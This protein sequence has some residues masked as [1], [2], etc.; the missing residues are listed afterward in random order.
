M[1]ATSAASL[2]SL[3]L[4][5]SPLVYLAGHLP[6]QTRWLTP[7]L[8]ALAAFGA[9][10]VAYLAVLV[11]LRAQGALQLSVEAV[12]LRIDGI[13]LLVSGLALALGTVVVIYS[14]PYVAGDTGEEK[15]YAMIMAMIGAI[16]GLVCAQDLFNLWIWFETMA[17]SSYLLVAFHREQL[18]SL[19]AGVKYLVQSA[20]GSALVLLGVALVLAQTGTLSLDQIRRLGAQSPSIAAAGALFIIGFGVKIALVPL[21][22]W[23]PDAH[24][25]APSGVS[26]LL[27]GIVIEAG[28]I[29]LLRALSPLTAISWGEWLVA[30]ALL[31]IFFGNLLALRQQE[32]KRLLAFSSV[33]QIGY[34]LLG[35]GIA[36]E[37][38]RPEGAQ[39]GLLHL[40]THG[41]MKGLSFLAVGALFYALHASKGDHRPLVIGDLQ[42]AARRYPLTTAALTIALIGLAG[43]PPT[44]GFVSKF[45]V[46]AAGVAAGDS[47]LLLATA[48]AAVNSLLSIAYYIPLVI[49]LYRHDS[50]AEVEGGSAVPRSMTVPMAAMALS[51]LVIGVVP[52]LLQWLTAL[53]GAD[54]VAWIR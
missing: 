42:G 9:M 50:G 11:D 8:T 51:V 52:N 30:F 14:G 10:W 35:L 16:I 1:F 32:V 20:C 38:G 37:T 28:L 23:L 31:N 47:A 6:R 54:V 45:Q 39:A 43:I 33:S 26:A 24:A 15:Y 22:T 25:Q 36:L 3:P 21:H 53:A 12:F 49:V 18:G 27:S 40:L 7:R 2:I 34:M 41:V 17:I 5:A 4:V 48:F 46:L 13:S 29:A 19:E 44:A